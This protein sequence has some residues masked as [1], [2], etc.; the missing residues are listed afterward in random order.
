MKK[1]LFAI[2]GPLITAMVALS[3]CS[4]IKP[5]ITPKI[6]KEASSSMAPSVISGQ[7]IKNKTL[8]QKEYVPFFGSSELSRL[9]RFHPSVL[10]AKYNRP[11]RPFLLGAAGTQSLTQFSMAASMPKQ[12]EKRKAIFIISPQWFVKGGVNEQYF[13]HWFSPVQTYAW[14][15]YIKDQKSFSA[16][17]QYYAKRLESFDIVTSNRRLKPLIQAIENNQPFTDNQKSYINRTYDALVKEDRM[18]SRIG[19]T[20]SHQKTIEHDE[21]LLPDEYNYKDLNL[22]AINVGK[23]AS[24]SNRF[25]IQNSFY[26]QRLRAN[27]A[28]LKGSQRN[29]D[30]RYSPEYSDFELVLNE[31]AKNQTDVLF[32]IPPVNDK[33]SD[34]TGLSQKMLNETAEKITYQLNEQGFHNVLNLNRYS[35]E[36]YFMNDTIHLGWRGWLRCDKAIQ[37]F[38]ESPY[39]P[40]NYHIDDYFYS[41]DWQN[42]RVDT[43]R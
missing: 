39:Q 2:F 19:L 22:L 35:E 18:Y 10:A 6:M 20:K 26:N 8:S 40:T 7:V 27:I 3:L 36:P 32:I 28:S 33:W 41:T 42:R 29:I 1:K 38:L 4:M 43:L 21:T 11:Y 31:F 30:Y 9:D 24:D 13:A 14:L 25:G 17:D 23:K 34:Y 12:L 15:D 37:P 16:S 5:Q